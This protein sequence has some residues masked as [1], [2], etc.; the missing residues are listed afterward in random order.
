M[1]ASLFADHLEQALTQAGVA[2]WLWAERGEPAISANFAA[3]LGCPADALPGDVDGWLDL[4]HEADRPA[5]A[6]LIADLRGHRVA[7]EVR[8]GVRLRGGD[9][10]WRHFALGAAPA[11]AGR[12]LITFND[13]T[14]ALRTGQESPGWSRAHRRARERPRHAGQES[15][16]SPVPASCRWPTT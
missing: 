5:L 6:A 7:S 9:G 4:A 10:D 16:P 8:F 11:G 14:D 15:S 12:T 13:I 2:F 3:R 1:P